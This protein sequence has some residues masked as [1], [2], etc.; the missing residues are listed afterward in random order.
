MERCE[1][2]KWH[3]HLQNNGW[4]NFLASQLLIFFCQALV[5]SQ[6]LSLQVQFGLNLTLKSH[7]PTTPPITFKPKYGLSGPSFK[8]QN[9]FLK[10]QNTIS[11][12]FDNTC[13]QLKADQIYFL[14]AIYC[15]NHFN[16]ILWSTK[17]YFSMSYLIPIHICVRRF[18]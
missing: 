1:A 5:Q 11:P 16:T 6:K 2:F 12:C 10:S 3:W 9:F 8:Y 14:L 13:S 15:H 17:L 18:H 4:H 7:R